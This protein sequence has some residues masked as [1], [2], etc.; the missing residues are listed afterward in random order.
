MNWCLCKEKQ[1]LWFCMKS[2]EIT[3]AMQ[4]KVPL[5]LSFDYVKQPHLSFEK[6]V[7]EGLFWML[8]PATFKDLKQCTGINTE[9]F[10]CVAAMVGPECKR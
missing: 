4:L 2:V 7:N 5:W 3:H 9:V 6:L 8:A 10:K 1:Y